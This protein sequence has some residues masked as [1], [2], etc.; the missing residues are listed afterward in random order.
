MGRGGDRRCLRRSDDG[1]PGP[2]DA[3]RVTVGKLVLHA[4]GGF[5]PRQLPRR[6]YAPI[7]FQGHA[8]IAMKDGSVPP[9]VQRIRLDF[10]RDGRLTT[11]GLPVC[12][13]EQI[14]G[15]TT[16]QA[17]SRCGGAMSGTETSGRPRSCRSPGDCRCGR[18]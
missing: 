7:H 9:A 15:A 6:T 14:Q 3:A 13:P 4:D 10:D 1:A 8:E 2:A 18:R 16:E 5:T 17:R 11:G 12:Q